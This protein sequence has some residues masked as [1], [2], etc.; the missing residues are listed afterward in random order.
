MTGNYLIMATWTGN[1]T[2]NGVNKTVDFALTPDSQ[3]NGQ[4]VFSVYSNSTITQFAFNSTSNELSFVVSGP[5]GT[6]GYV[7]ICIPK[8]HS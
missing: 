8:T 4:N 2:L 3:Q 7:N 6:T 1:S 5:S